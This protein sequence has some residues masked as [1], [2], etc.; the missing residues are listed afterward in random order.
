[1]TR[2][3]F[4]GDPGAT[5]EQAIAVHWKGA[6]RP[7][8]MP[9]IDEL[10]A[11]VAGG[12][13]DYGIIPLW[14]STS[15]TV[16]EGAAALGQGDD[17]IEQVATFLLPVRYALLGVPGLTLDRVR[18]AGSERGALEQCRAFLARHRGLLAV[19]T[20]DSARAA[21]ELADLAHGHTNPMRRPWYA[22]LPDARAESLAVI[23]RRDVATPLG[24]EP[25]ADDIQDRPDNATRF[26]VIRARRSAWRW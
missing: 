7:V 20:P 10:V 3:A 19:V 8:P 15:G 26:V 18:A 17:R 6:A 1:M 16:R 13:V 22:A 4:Q 9:S 11:A 12:R 2:V 25:L 14:N 21:R 24:L 5:A 23:A